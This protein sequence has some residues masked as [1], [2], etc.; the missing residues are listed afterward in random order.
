MFFT[1]SDLLGKEFVINEEFIRRGLARN[2]DEFFACTKK[3]I[4][5]FWHAPYYQANSAIKEFG[6]KAGYTYISPKL[7]DFDNVTLEQALF[8]NKKYV[9]TADLIDEI[10][11]VLKI[12]GGGIVPV[13]VG[14]SKGSR[15]D[16]LYNYLPLLLSAILDEGYKVI[17]VKYLQQ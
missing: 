7:K 5:L 1:S 17:P 6:A 11:N 12:S 13:T 9:S 8:E 15:V 14:I 16:Y 3:E 10:M 2:E 4:S